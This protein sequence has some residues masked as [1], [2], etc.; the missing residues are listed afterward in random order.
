MKKY[1]FP[2]D[3]LAVW[4]PTWSKN[5]GRSLLSISLNKLPRWDCNRFVF[6][7]FFNV[8]GSIRVISGSGVA[9]FRCWRIRFRIQAF[10]ISNGFRI[11]WSTWR[12][13]SFP[14]FFLLFEWGWRNNIRLNLGN[15]REGYYSCNKIATT[16]IQISRQNWNG[17][18][19]NIS[20]QIMI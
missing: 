8:R 10:N 7:E 14:M 3:A 1:F 20:H 5:L 13:V 16:W 15:N 9:N 11:R 19:S 18:F 12:W 2:I 4:C 6:G 17:F